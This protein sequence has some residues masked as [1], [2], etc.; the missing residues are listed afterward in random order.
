VYVQHDARIERVVRKVVHEDVV[1]VRAERV[2][3]GAQQV[4]RERAGDG[5]VLELDGDGVGFG[6]PDPDREIAIRGLLLQNHHALVIHQAD[7][8]ALDRHLYQPPTLRSGRI[9]SSYGPIGVSTKRG[10][11]PALQHHGTY[12]AAGGGR[13]PIDHFASR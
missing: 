12:A 8:D 3:D 4:V 7:P 1:D 11:A 5:D 2:D 10:R 6:R 9:Q 13:T